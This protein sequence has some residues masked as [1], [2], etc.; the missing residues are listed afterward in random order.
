LKEDAPTVIEVPP[1]LQGIL[2][3]FFQRPICSKGQID[4]H[5]W[6]GD[7]GFVGP[8]KGKVLASYFTL[9]SRTYGVL[10]F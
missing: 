1:K 8:G 10:V 7:V 3:D 4:R 5:V 9:R 6:C 2:D